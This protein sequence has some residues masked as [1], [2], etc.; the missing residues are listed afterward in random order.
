VL[1]VVFSEEAALRGRLFLAKAD[2]LKFAAS[3]AI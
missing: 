2:R 3:P 1:P